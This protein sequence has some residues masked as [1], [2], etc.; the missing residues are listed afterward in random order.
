M[1]CRFSK[2]QLKPNMQTPRLRNTKS[3][4]SKSKRWGTRCSRP[5]YHLFAVL[6]PKHSLEKGARSK[7][8]K[9]KQS[10]QQQPPLPATP[11]AQC[12]GDRQ[13][14]QAELKAIAVEITFGKGIGKP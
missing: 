1:F 11:H 9:P 5:R 4:S 7:I 2:V 6:P 8:R 12:P 14:S 13:T 3:E 10:F